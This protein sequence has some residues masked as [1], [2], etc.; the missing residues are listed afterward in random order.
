MRK[1]GVY[2]LAVLACILFAAG[3]MSPAM[4][5]WA[6]AIKGVVKSATGDS[7]E[8]TAE[9]SSTASD[10]GLSETEMNS[11]IKEALHQAVT[12]AIASL[13]RENGFL[14]NDLVKIPVPD[15]LAQ[16]ESILRKLG[17]DELVDN[18]VESMNRAAEKAVPKTTEIL[19]GA[20]TSMTLTEA[21]EILQGEDDAATQYFETKTRD[22]LFAEI[23]PVVQEATDSARVTSYYKAMMDKASA[24]MPLLQSYSPDLDEYVTGKALDGLFVIMAQ[25]EKKIRDNPAAR[26]TELLEKVW[27][28]F[29]N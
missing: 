27:G 24:S 4:A 13:G 23:E 1:S 22:Q 21:A 18:F 16:A 9:K 28:Y 7:S 26:T 15:K 29:G 11:G 3:V 14:S 17:Q 8:E 20:V 19:G 25:E 10:S 12:T 6:D 5:G 2:V